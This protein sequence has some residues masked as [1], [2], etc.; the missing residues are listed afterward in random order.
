MDNQNQPS[1]NIQVPCPAS[2]D[3]IVLTRNVAEY[4]K[5]HYPNAQ[6]TLFSAYDVK[7]PFAVAECANE[8]YDYVLTLP[9]TEIDGDE[10]GEL[11]LRLEKLLPSFD[12]IAIWEALDRE[13]NAYTVCIHFPVSSRTPLPEECRK[14][15]EPCCLSSTMNSVVIQVYRMDRH[16]TL[17]RWREDVAHQSPDAIL[18]LLQNLA[19]TLMQ[20]ARTGH[21]LMRFSPDTIAVSEHTIRFMGIVSLDLPWNERCV[22]SYKLVELGSIPPECHGFLRQNITMSQTLYVFCA[23]AYFLIANALPP[24]CS[25]LDYEPAVMPRA[26]NPA[27][28][29]GLDEVIMNGLNPTPNLRPNLMADVL[30]A[31][32][33]QADIMSRRAASH[34]ET[35]TYDAALETHI[36]IAKCLRCPI[37][38]DVVWMQSLDDERWLIVVGDG[39]STST[40]GSGDIAS[41]LLVD[42]A[43]KAWKDAIS[44]DKIIDPSTCI[45]SIIL[46][47]NQ[48]ICLYIQEH[49]GHLNPASCDCMGSTAIVAIIEHGVLT[50]GSIG[51]SRAYIIR[52]DTMLCITRDHN[53]FTIGIINQVPVEICA[54]HPHA[55]SLVQCLGYNVDE[56]N[57]PCPIE[58]DVYQIPLLDGD[59]L[60]ITTDGILDYIAY[61]LK[62]SESAIASVVRHE[63]TAKEICH[64]LIM[65]ANLGGGGDN[66]S[67]AMICVHQKA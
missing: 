45:R 55:G 6:S 60:L 27:F 22:E 14:F 40:Y 42:A 18:S 65:Q 33:A 24:V 26:F 28:P 39:V 7:S 46:E 37:N 30:N 59:N 12:S 34:G 11:H 53:L 49:F 36:G 50:L 29:I 44:K 56:M 25:A 21:H 54:T 67:V 16:V 32:R 63:K 4:M 62:M 19:E 64:E 38:Q 8:R 35:L 66:C 43:Q 20:I 3:V 10:N 61:D 57:N 1:T 31:F 15:M 41:H 47:A 13:F 52:D 58:F 17:R 2:D 9:E 48:Q 51:D 23:M 5:Q